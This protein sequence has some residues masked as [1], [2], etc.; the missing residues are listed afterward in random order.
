M[1]WLLKKPLR[2]KKEKEAKDFCTM[3][4]LFLKLRLHVYIK[5]TVKG[6]KDRTKVKV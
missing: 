3:K 1:I 6:I 2:I 5:F 4:S